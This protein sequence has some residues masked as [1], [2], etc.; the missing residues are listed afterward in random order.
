[1]AKII[2]TLLFFSSMAEAG[3]TEVCYPKQD[4]CARQLINVE[5]KS[6]MYLDFRERD[7][8]R[9]DSETKHAMTEAG[10][11]LIHNNDH[12][13]DSYAR[14]VTRHVQADVAEDIEDLSDIDDAT[15]EFIQNGFSCVGAVA[16]CTEGALLAPETGGLSLFFSRLGCVASGISCPALIRSTQKWM[17]AQR[18]AAERSGQATGGTGSRV[19]NS[20]PVAAD[21]FGVVMGAGDWYTPR[22]GTV[23][24]CPPGNHNPNCAKPTVPDHQM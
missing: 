3:W 9:I 24:D 21:E 16:V 22:F 13:Y 4:I 14:T 8:A 23:D 20:T 17:K 12:V 7:Y 5:T 19:D 18:K 15:W 6:V 1:M 10:I 11:I 2:L